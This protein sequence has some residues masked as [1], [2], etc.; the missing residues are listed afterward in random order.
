[1]SAET[2]PGE[3]KQAVLLVGG[4]GTRLRPLTHTRPKALVPLLNRPLLSYELELLARHGVRDVILAVSYQADQLRA[5]LGEG[6]R[7][8]LSLRYVEEAEPL[9][10]AGGIKNVEALIEGPFLA[11]NGDLV[12]EVDLRELGQAHLESEAVLTLCLRRVDDISAFG[13]IRRDEDGWVTAFLE[14]VEV[15]ETGQNTVNSGVYVMS[16]EILEHIPPGEECSN[17]HQLFPGLLEAGQRVYGHVP[18]AWGYWNDVGRLDGYLEANRSLLNGALSWVGPGMA[19]DVKVAEGAEV[20]EP[21]LLGEGATIGSGATVGPW[22]TLGEGAV[23]GEGA[24][25]S[26]SILWP[27]ATVGR[28]ARVKGSVVGEAASVGDDAE[29]GGGAIVQ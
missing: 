6:E 27:R 25:V 4:L 5:E 21:C 10:T 24:R 15:D 2:V 14:K 20:V 29:L 3:V 16:P 17:E 11:F 28:G 13:L 18:S 22:V 12:M 1:V 23:I 26:D 9:G 7:W 8:G 19:E